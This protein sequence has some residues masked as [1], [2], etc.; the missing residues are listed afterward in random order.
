MDENRIFKVRMSTDYYYSGRDATGARALGFRG[1]P[2]MGLSMT[3]AV[4]CAVA[5]RL[6]EIGYEDAICVDSQGI[7]ISPDN[8][9][10]SVAPD[11][12]EEAWAVRMD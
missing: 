8:P 1:A 10:Q 5:C 9:P 2:A 7:P 4:A 3:Y 6:V 11:E 12:F